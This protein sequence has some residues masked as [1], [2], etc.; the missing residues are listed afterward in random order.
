MATNQ[1]RPPLVVNEPAPGKKETNCIDLFFFADGNAK[2]TF[3][4]NVPK[5][6]DS[7]GNITKW[8]KQT[9]YE[10]VSWIPK[11]TDISKI[12]HFDLKLVQIID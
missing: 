1:K 10:I 4:R 2:C 8:E 3:V 12:K 6:K 9:Y 5:E 11:N 7:E